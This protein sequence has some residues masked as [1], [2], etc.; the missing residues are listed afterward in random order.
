[1][2]AVRAPAVGHERLLRSR[3]PQP[4]HLGCLFWLGFR[5]TVI[6]GPVASDAAHVFHFGHRLRRLAANLSSSS[7]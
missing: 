5:R 4:L 2:A 6:P 7:C 1:M 3:H